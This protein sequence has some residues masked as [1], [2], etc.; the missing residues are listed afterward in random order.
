M[1]PRAPPSR[2]SKL[3]ETRFE[4][5]ELP[6]DRVE[7]SLVSARGIELHGPWGHVFGPLDIDIE[8]AV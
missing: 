7:G 3:V 1:C 2:E 5:W 8:L 6:E 4:R